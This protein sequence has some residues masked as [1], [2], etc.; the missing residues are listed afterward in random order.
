ML[1]RPRTQQV[2]GR[3]PLAGPLPWWGKQPDRAATPRRMGASSH[4]D[5]SLLA[6]VTEVNE[7]PEL[8]S[9]KVGFAT[10]LPLMMM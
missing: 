6:I 8:V 10:K 2:P 7:V 3:L 9:L 4:A 5:H 1:G